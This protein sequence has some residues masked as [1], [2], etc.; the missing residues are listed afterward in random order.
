MNFHTDVFGPFHFQKARGLVPVKRDFRIGIVMEDDQ[1]IFFGK[2]DPFF[3]DGF[4][5]HNGCGR[6]VWVVQEH[7]LALPGDL[8]GD[9]L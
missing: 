9:L 2:S 3:E 5:V 7:Q 1:V 8:L 4:I 6:V